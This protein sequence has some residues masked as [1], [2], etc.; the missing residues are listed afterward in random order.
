M[1]SPKSE[2]FSPNVNHAAPAVWSGRSHRTK[3]SSAAHMDEDE[4]A[5]RESWCLDFVR[6]LEEHLRSHSE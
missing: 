1:C 2:P 5:E 3:A 6:D 4:G